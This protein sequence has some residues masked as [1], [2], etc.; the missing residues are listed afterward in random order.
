MFTDATGSHGF[1]LQGGVF[2]PIDFP[3]ATS[4]TAFGINDSGEIAGLYSDATGDTHGFIFS[5]GAFSTV[6]VVGATDTMLTRIKNDGVVT[7]VFTD[8]LGEQH[9]LTGR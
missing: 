6:D 2:S 8:A 5:S 1:L 9:G 4:T 3:L 7:G